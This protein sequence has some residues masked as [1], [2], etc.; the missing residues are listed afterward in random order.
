MPLTNSDQGYGAVTKLCHW[1]VAILFFCQYG[2][3]AIMRHTPDDG[4]ILGMT[5]GT[6][7]DWHKS[8]G[9]VVLVAMVIR[10]INR[11]TGELPPWAPTLAPVEKI[12]IHRAEQLLYLL[13][14]VMPLSGLIYVFAAGYGVRLFGV[15][16]L[17][18]VI[19][20]ASGLATIAR[21]V[22][23]VTS[24]LLLLPVGAHVFLVL[25]HHVGL[26]DGLIRRMLPS[27]SGKPSD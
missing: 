7:Y 14:F 27:G 9:L 26:K 18:N 8:L 22:H 5:Q 11:R 13:M 16:D 10:L 3:A 24:M 4:A 15:V 21:W 1:V 2:L 25:G 23:I 20:K 6:S 12:I 17:P 19:G